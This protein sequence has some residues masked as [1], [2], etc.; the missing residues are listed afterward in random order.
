M[1]ST[2]GIEASF[3]NDLFTMTCPL[4]SMGYQPLCIAVPKSTTTTSSTNS[5]PEAVKQA[6]TESQPNSIWFW[7][8]SIA[9]ILLIL[10]LFALLSNARSKSKLVSNELVKAKA[11]C[12]KLRMK[13]TEL[14]I[15]ARTEVEEPEIQLPSK[16]NF[17]HTYTTKVFRTSKSGEPIETC[18]DMVHVNLKDQ[19]FAIADGVSQ[20]FNS[21]KWAELLVTTASKPNGF[22]SLLN[23]VPTI[24]SDWENDCKLLLKDE[25]P[26][27]FLLQKQLQGS[28]STLAT[29]KLMSQDGV[30]NWQ[31]NTI[32]DSLLIVLDASES[33]TLIRKFYPWSRADDFPAGPDIVSTRRPFLRGHIKTFE[34][35]SVVG[36]KLLLMTD[37]MARYAVINGAIGS[38]IAKV[39]PFLESNDL[40]FESWI[41]SARQNGLGDDDSTLI[42]ISPHYE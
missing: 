13:N 23:Q 5:I 25:E 18:A 30:Q 21:A 41:T 34:F 16:S 36:E 15:P 14:L 6:V 4:D 33:S 11:E 12:R 9:S 35:E 29:L 19:V 39:F 38:E 27:S 10:F 26:Q 2:I 31:F 28:Q 24:S 42:L 22:M 40:D 7:V 1:P 20:S 37:A 32:G 8:A 3:I 17:T